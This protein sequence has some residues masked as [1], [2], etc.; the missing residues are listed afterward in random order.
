MLVYL[1]RSDAEEQWSTG[2]TQSESD[3]EKDWRKRVTNFQEWVVHAR[4][5]S[6]E[7]AQET[8]ATN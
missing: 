2:Y 1:G 6:E 3:S 8:E 4:G 5:L 7:E